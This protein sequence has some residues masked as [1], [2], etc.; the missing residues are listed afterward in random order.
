V[1]KPKKQEPAAEAMTSDDWNLVAAPSSDLAAALAGTERP[2]HILAALK[3]LEKA[4]SDHAEWLKNWHVDLLGRLDPEHRSDAMETL[5][6]FVSWYESPR[7]AVLKDNPAYHEIGA[8]MRAMLGAAEEIVEIVRVTGSI[9]A[10]AYGTFMNTVL[11]FNGAVR[12]LQAE[13]WNRLANID[14]LTGIGNRQAMI[15]RLN[16]EFERQARYQHSCCIAMFDID[17]FKDVNDTHGHLVGDTILR[18]VASVLASSIRP[19]DQV[20]RYGGEE[21]LMC[22]PGTDARSSWA[23]VERLRLK[24]A[25]WAIPIG[26]DRDLHVT[27]SVGVAPLSVEAGVEGTLVNADSA[28]YAAKRN[29]RNRVFIWGAQT[30]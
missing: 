4:M 26:G 12:S 14:P 10:D 18:S 17:H 2:E 8:K 29:G 27:V 1:T 16:V 24:V 23:I 19:Y 5:G 30:A 15:D 21:F 7:Q 28:L 3:D 22:L 6:R 25:N 11:E 13:T 20:F 9:P